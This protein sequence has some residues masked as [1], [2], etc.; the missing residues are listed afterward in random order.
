MIE[1]KNITKSY[2][3]KDKKYIGKYFLR[4]L[5]GS[6]KSLF[7]KNSH[8][9]DK[10]ILKGISFRINDGERVAIVGK[11]KAGKTTLLQLITGISDPSSGSL[12]VK[13][14]IIPIFA[15]AHLLGPDPTG[16]EYIFLHGA[17]LG[18]P[19]K[20][21]QKRV[22]EIITFSEITTIDTPVK[23]YSTGMR[24]RLALSVALHLPADIIVLDEVFSGSDVFFKDKVIN[25]MQQRFANE[26]ITLVM[27]SH[28]ENII[29]ALCNRALLLEDGK[30]TKDGTPDDILHEYMKARKD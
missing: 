3:N 10:L 30:I 28:N 4:N 18:I 7:S 23:F 17:A 12:L 20:Q 1:L 29:K 24:S 8:D 26:N 15:Q 9:A 16:R 19:I 21:I 25:F 11:N 6:L 2:S 5:F 14:K 22:E 27:I 13:G